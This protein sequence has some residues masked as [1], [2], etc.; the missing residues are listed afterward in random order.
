MTTSNRMYNKYFQLFLP[1]IAATFLI[2]GCAVKTGAKYPDCVIP[3]LSVNKSRIYFLHEHIFGAGSNVPV[4]INNIKIVTLNAG[5]FYYYDTLPGQYLLEVYRSQGIRE[6]GA[7]RANLR[8]S[9]NKVY[10]LVIE[11]RSKRWMGE[12]V[13][14]IGSAAMAIAQVGSTKDTSE[15]LKT[16]DSSGFYKVELIDEATA[17]KKLKDLEIIIQ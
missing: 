12:M 13:G 5:S 11:M 9:P 7:T 8:V 10:Y 17:K 3:A 2:I 14:P 1:F 15:D 4:K 16:I 6:F